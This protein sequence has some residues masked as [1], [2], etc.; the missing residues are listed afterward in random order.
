MIH[1]RDLAVG[2]RMPCAS[3]WMDGE[4]NESKR[5]SSGRVSTSFTGLPRALAAS[6]A[7]TV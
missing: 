2:R 4:R 3:V 6:A 5:M 7:G 1:R